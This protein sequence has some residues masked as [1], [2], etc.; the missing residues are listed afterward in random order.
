MK[1]GAA[2]SAGAVAALLLLIGLPVGAILLQPAFPGLTRGD[3]S[4][5]FSGVAAASSEP[6]MLE[7]IGNTLVE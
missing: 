3:F 2:I 6:R 5:P 4:A 7:L 1:G